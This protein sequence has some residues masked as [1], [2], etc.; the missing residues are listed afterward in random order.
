[1]P[2]CTPQKWCTLQEG[3][4]K[5]AP[6]IWAETLNFRPPEILPLTPEI[7]GAGNSAP[8]AGISA[9]AVSLYKG[10]GRGGVTPWYLFSPP[11]PIT[12]NRRRRLNKA[13]SGDS[14]AAGFPGFRR[15]LLLSAWGFSSSTRFSPWTAVLPQF[16]LSLGAF[17][18]DLDSFGLI[19]FPLKG[20]CLEVV[21]RSSEPS[22]ELSWCRSFF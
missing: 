10:G 9:P 11:T 2:P 5:F 18:L 4:R 15:S 13:L 20:A 17:A 19:R 12:P 16:S 6:E 3:G 14:L 1:M 8:R 22:I 21:F 7:P